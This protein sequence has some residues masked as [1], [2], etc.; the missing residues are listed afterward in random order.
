MKFNLLF[1]WFFAMVWTLVRFIMGKTMAIDQARTTGILTN[2][3]L[4]L[5]VIFLSMWFH[6]RQRP[7]PVNGFLDDIK[8]C[9]KDASKYIIGV[10]MGMG[11]YYGV[12][13]NDIEQFRNAQ[14]KAR[15]EE[16]GTDEGLK[17]YLIQTHSDASMTRAAVENAI[18][19]DVEN[20]IT[21]GKQISFGLPLLLIAAIFYAL[22]TVVF[23]RQ[24]LMK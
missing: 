15:L 9:V 17:N 13:T 22:L 20:Q 3:L 24:V 16:V 4:L 12:L 1:P 21:L 10:A 23:W 19:Q 5:S 2:I 18:I 8:R 7:A 14:M 11:L 6:Y